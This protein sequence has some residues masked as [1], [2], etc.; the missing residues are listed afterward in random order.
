MIR[1]DVRVRRKIKIACHVTLW[2]QL[3]FE[4]VAVQHRAAHQPYWAFNREHGESA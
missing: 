1:A 4:R 3:L 2:V